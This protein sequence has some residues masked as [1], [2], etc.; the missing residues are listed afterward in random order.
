MNETK[1]IFR[2]W[3]GK[4]GTVIA[5]FPEEL[6]TYDPSICYSYEHIGQGGSYRDYVVIKRSRLA[7]PDEYA[8]LQSELESRG[9]S[10]K[11]IQRVPSAAY[12][13]RR[14]AMSQIYHRP[15]TDA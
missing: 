10:L 9:Y 13:F 8:D 6:G 4:D 5:I 14:Q 11:I 3:N 12:E 7:K 1:V 2:K 15:P